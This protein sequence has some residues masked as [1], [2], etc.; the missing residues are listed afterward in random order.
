[1]S[2]AFLPKLAAAAAGF[3]AV[4]SVPGAA[5]LADLAGLA[6]VLQRGAG[7]SPL[8]AVVLQELGLE[9]RQILLTAPDFRSQQHDISP[10]PC[11]L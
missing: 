3:A 1:M 5:G 11:F 8:Q 4:A 9:H 6:A 7:M 2:L 10:V